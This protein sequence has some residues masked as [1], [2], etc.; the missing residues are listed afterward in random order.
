MEDDRELKLKELSLREAQEKTKQI[1]AS[2]AKF[3]KNEYYLH[4]FVK[5]G[6]KYESMDM[7]LALK[8]SIQ[9]CVSS[10]YGIQSFK[11]NKFML[12]END[13]LSLSLGSLDFDKIK[14]SSDKIITICL[15]SDVSLKEKGDQLRTHFN[16]C[17]YER[18]FTHMLCDAV[19][20]T[21]VSGHVYQVGDL[22]FDSSKLSL[23][24]VGHGKMPSQTV[25]HG[26]SQYEIEI[27]RGRYAGYLASLHAAD[28]FPPGMKYTIRFYKSQMEPIL[29]QKTLNDGAPFQII[30]ARTNTIEAEAV[31]ENNL[32]NEV[33]EGDKTTYLRGEDTST[34][35]F[36]FTPHLVSNRWRVGTA[37]PE[38]FSFRIHKEVKEQPQPEKITYSV[39]PP[40]QH[41]SN[42]ST[43]QW[44]TENKTLTYDHFAGLSQT[45]WDSKPHNYRNKFEHC[46]QISATGPDNVSN[47]S[48]FD[49]KELRYANYFEKN[50][51]RIKSA[52]TSLERT[53]FL[54]DVQNLK[55]VYDRI[56]D[57]RFTRAMP[58][59]PESSRSQLVTTL[60]L[61]KKGVRS[62][63]IFID[64][65]G[66]EKVD[67]SKK[68]IVTCESVY[69]NSTLKF[70]TDMFLRMKEEYPGWKVDTRQGQ[71]SYT[72]IKNPLLKQ[73]MPPTKE[74]FD[75]NQPDATADPFQRYLYN[76]STP[77]AG[78]K[79]AIVMV[80]C[81]YEYYS[82]WIPPIPKPEVSKESLEKTFRF[83][84]ALFH[85]GNPIATV[86]EVQQRA[87]DQERYLVGGGKRSTRKHKPKRSINYKRP[88]SKSKKKR[89]K[90]K[91]LTHDEHSFHL[92]HEEPSIF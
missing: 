1:M 39:V 35:T 63:L 54:R 15:G 14:E 90:T 58:Q 31:E 33:F 80:V 85:F 56:N 83:I 24:T 37:E 79:P 3:I 9:Q 47:Y 28:R 91:H 19:P 49:H 48:L 29:I 41:S 60:N 5:Q 76:I 72:S 81:A 71:V 61:S 21:Y 17:M 27:T 10:E 20:V 18:I 88:R 46:I 2:Y 52:H 84:S 36:K 23:Q 22:F 26:K 50:V 82:S 55:F 89:I 87:I 6:E 57:F 69:I 45:G 44:K 59:N 32:L 62:K 51:D 43:D 38:L 77:T 8:E 67:T 42:M 70:V 66:N 16:T 73:P 40:K 64:L 4:L 74:Q 78:L 34:A 12:S 75:Y 11:T 7:S 68:H 65:A 92:N 25:R 13:L 53:T 30:S 86:G